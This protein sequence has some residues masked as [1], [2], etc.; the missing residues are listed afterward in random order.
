MGPVFGVSRFSNKVAVI[1]GAEHPVAASLCRRMAG[2]GATVVAVGRD[3]D[4]LMAV[5]R[6]DPKRIEPLALEGGRRDVLQ[7]LREAWGDEP[8]DYYADFLPLCPG[9]VAPHEVFAQS[10]GMG[11][12]LESGMRAGGAL[13]MMALPV[14]GDAYHENS[15]I[16]AGYDPLLKRMS[17]AVRPG[18]F[19]GLRLRQSEDAWRPEDCISAGDMVLTL[20]HPVSRGLKNGTIVDWEPEGA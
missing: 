19:V 8:L 2:F 16:A 9:R 20:F 17:E 4:A 6:F 3:A 18:R 11:R 7:L 13:C 10:V 14:P 5:A 12:A 1:A 15:F